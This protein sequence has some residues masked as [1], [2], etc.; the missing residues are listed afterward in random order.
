MPF[1]PAFGSTMT[2]ATRSAPKWSMRCADRGRGRASPHSASSLLPNGQR[3]A[4]G[5]ST[6]LTPI[7]SGSIMRA[8]AG[9][10]GERHRE[11][12]R[13]VVRAVA[14]DDHAPRL[15]AG[16]ANDLH[17]VL[18]GI[19][20]AER[21]EHAAA[22]ESGQ[23]QQALGQLGAGPCSPGIRDEAELFGLRTDR[24]HDARVLVAEVAALGEAAHVEDRVG[25]LRDAA[26]RRPRRQPSVRSSATAR[27]SCAG[28]GLARNSRC[29][30]GLVGCHDCAVIAQSF[31]LRT[32]LRITKLRVK[33]QSGT[34]LPLRSRLSKAATTSSRW[35]AGW[36][37]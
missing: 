27:T 30:R 5:G 22:L 29:P 9:V 31:A 18:V 4:Y 20:A 19:G 2:A 35:P 12:R 25:R 21:E 17:G 3:Y 1:E 37:C 32:M 26:M 11:V 36:Q 13:A 8:R 16:L 28:P 7:A 15:A 34:H 6:W 14:G 10:A 33:W 23:L 24:G